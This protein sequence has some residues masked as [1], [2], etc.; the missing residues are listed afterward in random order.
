MII[1]RLT[2]KDYGNLV[3][4]W[5]K[6]QLPFKQMGRDSEASVVS[7]MNASPDFFLGAFE[8]SHL[9][10]AVIITCDSRKGWIN[11]LAVDPQ[12]RRGG[13]AKALIAE[14][15]KVLGE[16]GVSIICALI[17]SY[18]VQSKRLFKECGYVE[19]R[20]IVYFSKRKSSEV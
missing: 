11:R 12:Y 3:K 9:V 19:H 4:L 17:E 10:G 13:I 2:P 8:D 15:E 14:S 20:D 1:K 5:S 16:R 6:A 7:E 18:N